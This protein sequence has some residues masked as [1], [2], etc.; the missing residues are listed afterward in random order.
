M[1]NK[2]IISTAKN[3]FESLAP[4]FVKYTDEILFGDC[5]RREELSLRD[6]SLIT[7]SVLI[8]GQNLGQLDYHLKLAKENGLKEAEIIEAIT[9]L[10]FYVGWPKAASS[11]EIAKKVFKL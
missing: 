3:S 2:A 5:W 8:T 10:A 4:A 6:R 7:V 11:L 9:H 1:K